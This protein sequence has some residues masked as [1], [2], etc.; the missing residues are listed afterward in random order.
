M[1]PLGVHM[2]FCPEYLCK[3]IVVSGGGFD[4]GSHLSVF[5]VARM[6][7]CPPWGGGSCL[8]VKLAVSDGHGL[9]LLIHPML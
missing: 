5:P 2:F 1:R 8:G 7:L 9:D 6:L 4:S 3:L